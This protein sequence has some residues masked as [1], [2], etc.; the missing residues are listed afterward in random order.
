MGI[1]HGEKHI[2]K[3]T[4]PSKRII[5]THIYICQKYKGYDMIQHQHSMSE[6]EQDLGSFIPCG[7]PLPALAS[8]AGLPI[9]SALQP[10]DTCG[11]TTG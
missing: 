3:K 11:T 6:N 10:C 2:E 8:H 4:T 9:A 7:H 1:R 5:H